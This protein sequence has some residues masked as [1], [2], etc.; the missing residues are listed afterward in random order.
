MCDLSQNTTPSQVHKDIILFT[1]LAL[2]VCHASSMTWRVGQP[3]YVW[4]SYS[5]LLMICMCWKLILAIPSLRTSKSK[6]TGMSPKTNVLG[7][8]N[9]PLS[10]YWE[11][12]FT[13]GCHYLLQCFCLFNLQSPRCLLLKLFNI[14]LCCSLYFC[15]NSSSSHPCPHLNPF[16]PS[17]P[18]FPKLFSQ[19]SLYPLPPT[20]SYHT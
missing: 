12:W 9:K 14:S 2:S 18:I 5:W 10:L 6:L 4:E 8:G 15:R 16:Q 1:D 17:L 3:I 19:P 13:E 7:A 11:S 20:P